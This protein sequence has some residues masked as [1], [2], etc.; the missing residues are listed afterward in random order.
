ME[1]RCLLF[2]SLYERILAADRVP[3]RM[4]VLFD[5]VA[6]VIESGRFGPRLKSHAFT[7]RN[8]S[9]EAVSH[10]VAIDERRTMFRPQLWP[11]GG[12]FMANPFNRDTA[13][14]QDAE[15]EIGRAHV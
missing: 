9:V 2:R 12:D 11:P 4:L 15:E 1:F 10:A 6:S 3:I 5:T 14:R 8:T 7:A 13:R